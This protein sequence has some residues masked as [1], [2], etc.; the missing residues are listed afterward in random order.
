MTHV[1]HLLLYTTEGCHL[2][3]QAKTLLWPRLEAWGL[4]L[5]EVDIADSEE[6][7]ELYGVRIPVI[8]LSHSEE[9][10]A[11]PFNAVE[12]ELFLSDNVVRN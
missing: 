12:L 6:L 8:R 5:E 10:L 7:V 9:E 3:E 1:V 4:N 11:W 2:C